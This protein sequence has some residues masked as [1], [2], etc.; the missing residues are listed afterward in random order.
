MALAAQPMSNLGHRIYLPEFNAK[1]HRNRCKNN[2]VTPLQ[3]AYFY[4]LLEISS[5]EN[6][7]RR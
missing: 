6:E 5:R 7:I 2:E 4:L 3:S 1:L